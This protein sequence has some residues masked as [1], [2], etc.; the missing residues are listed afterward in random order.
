MTKLISAFPFIVGIVMILSGVLSII[1]RIKGTI[2]TDGVI[3][4]IAKTMK[5]RSRVSIDLEAPIVRYKI[6]SVEY[7]GISRRFFTEGDMNL[8]KGSVIK[9]RV[10]KFDHRRFVPEDSGGIA[11]KLL[12]FGGAFMIAANT[13]ILLRYGG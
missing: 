12:V 9:I 5:K 10:N 2:H 4:D 13:V 3:I 8:K 6:G 11:E 7:R 1:F